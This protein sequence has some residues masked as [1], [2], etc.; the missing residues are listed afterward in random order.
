MDR[1]LQETHRCLGD[2]LSNNFML[3]LMLTLLLPALL[4][5]FILRAILGVFG[6]GALGIVKGIC[7]LTLISNHCGSHLF[8]QIRLLHGRS[9]LSSVVKSL[10]EA[11]LRPCRGLRWELLI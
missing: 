4:Q 11:G 8:T 9:V 5:N 2:F 3:Q 1:H 6:F 7:N 10:R